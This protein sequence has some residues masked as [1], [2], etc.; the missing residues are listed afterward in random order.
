[1]MGIEQLSAGYEY[2]CILKFN[3]NVLQISLLQLLITV[4]DGMKSMVTN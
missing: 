1:M 2:S 3:D 4:I